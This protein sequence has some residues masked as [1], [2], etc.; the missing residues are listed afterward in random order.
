MDEEDE[1]Q[2]EAQ[3]A[4]ESKNKTNHAAAALA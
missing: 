4:K 1:A 3:N 2:C